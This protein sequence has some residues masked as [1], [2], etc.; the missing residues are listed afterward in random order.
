[1]TAAT[2]H[3]LL[4][5]VSFL[6]SGGPGVDMDG[7][8]YHLTM[9][10]CR[11]GLLT[12]ALVS[13]VTPDTGTLVTLINCIATY[14]GPLALLHGVKG[15]NIIGGGGD[16]WTGDAI[17]IESCT[18][19][20]FG[21][22]IEGNVA[23]TAGDGIRIT[24]HRGLIAGNRIINFGDGGDTVFPI[25]VV[26]NCQGTTVLSNA[27]EATVST[28]S[29]SL[30][31]D[32]RNIRVENNVFDKTIIDA[33][34]DVSNRFRGNV[35][36][37]TEN[38]GTATIIAANTA[39]IVA[40]G[41]NYTPNASDIKVFLTNQPTADIGDVWI[42]TIGAANFTINCR[43]APGVATAIFAWSIDRTP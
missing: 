4:E 16:N 29:L 34:G 22:D 42:D 37:V 25:R 32:C 15:L 5:N 12:G 35:G 8:S 38:R 19:N 10:N 13:K 30:A 9:I 17:R 31:G 33:A 11:A 40:H 26:S 43:N 39:I 21:T 27:V 23:G 6:Y 7:A 2:S 18:G 3:I 41:C 36:Y 24:S 1:M 28:Y 20:V 14:G